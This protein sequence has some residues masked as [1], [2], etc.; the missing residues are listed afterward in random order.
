LRPLRPTS[1][2]LRPSRARAR[3]RALI[4]PAAAC[5]GLAAT[6]GPAVAQPARPADDFVDSVGVN[7][8]LHYDGTVYT[9]A[10]ESVIRPK[11]LGLGVRHVRDNA[12]TYAGANAQ[13]PFYARCRALAAAGIRFNLVTSIR[14]TRATPTDYSK[15]DDLYA[16]CGGGIAAFEGANEPDIQAIPAGAPS[17]S[18]QTIQGQRALWSAVK[19]NPA[20]GHVSVIGPS[21]TWT[22]QPLGDLSGL[23]D[24]GNAHPYPGGQCPTCG[25]PYGNNVDRALPRYRMPSG[26]RPLM[27]TETGYHNAVNGTDQG[28]RPA[29]EL[30]VGKY[31]PRLLLEYFNRGFA[32]TYLYQ[33]MD[34][35]PDPGRMVRDSNFGL[36]RNNGT[37]KPAYRAVKSLL[38]LLSD[39]GPRFAPGALNYT[40]TGATDRVHQTLLQKRDGTFYLALWQ[41]RSSYDTGARANAP[42]NRAARRDL[43]VP[44]QQVNIAVQTP[45][46]AA[47]VHR[48]TP[49]GSLSSQAVGLNQGSLSLPVSDRVTVVALAPQ[50]PGQGAGAANAAPRLDRVR[51]KHRV[52]APSQ[53][54]ARG[55]RRGS[56][57][58]RTNSLSFRLSEP[59]RVRIVVE[60]RLPGRRAARRSAS[61]CRPGKPRKAQKRC[62]RHRWA[63]TLRVSK[64]AGRQR[65]RITG[66]FKRRTLKS[67]RYRARVTAVDAA[68]ASSRERT[69]YFRVVRR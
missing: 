30:A 43:V 4:A 59:A 32:R 41:E 47:S 7:V 39:P 6:A 3:I 64:K 18:A 12:Y 56:R 69:V 33:L 44:E 5:I 25:D 20:I 60:R 24:F 40:L 26:S 1:D 22:P 2:Q 27:M 48:I 67:G 28:N 61:P 15:L 51:I 17:W 8:R 52:F 35:R 65:T 9:S 55:A 14:T 13:T 53:Q 31:T 45:I 29:T 49:D 46:R 19:G 23:M 63:G 58:P 21:I 66:R 34:L 57:R 68:G 54:R 36:V 50:T 10:F 62:Y 42:D 11:L 37:E 16:W 38:G